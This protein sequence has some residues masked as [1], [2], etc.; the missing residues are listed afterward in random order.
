MEKLTNEVVNIRLTCNAVKQECGKLQ[1]EVKSLALI[2][3][4][5]REE[6]KHTLLSIDARL[7]SLQTDQK[8]VKAAVDLSLAPRTEGTI[9]FL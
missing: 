1:Q 7:A 8:V 5:M 2:Q 6:F 3:S 4:Q 9:P